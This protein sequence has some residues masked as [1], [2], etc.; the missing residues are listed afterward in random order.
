MYFIKNVQIRQKHI[1]R[2]MD[3]VSKIFFSQNSLGNWYFRSVLKY[4]L[5][6][7]HSS[8][9]GLLYLFKNNNISLWQ[10]RCEFQGV[11]FMLC[12]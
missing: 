5:F 8:F 12:K 1:V 3:Y 7:L 6:F 11:V 9:N 4:F 10:N 2:N